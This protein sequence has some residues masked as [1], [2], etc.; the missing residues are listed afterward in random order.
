MIANCS[1]IIS[2]QKLKKAKQYF[3]SFQ[4]MKKYAISDLKIAILNTKFQKTQK[5]KK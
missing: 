1:K 3:R 5:L 4:T 2:F